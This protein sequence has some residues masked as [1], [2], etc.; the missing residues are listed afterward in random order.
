[1]RTLF[2][3][4]VISVA[5]L[6]GC[7]EPVG[8]PA[9]EAAVAA[10]RKFPWPDGDLQK[11]ESLFGSTIE[12]S[13]GLRWQPITPGTGDAHPLHGNTVTVHYRGT[14]LDGK[15]FDESYKRN[16]P[17]R[18]PVGMGRV[19]KGWDEAV[20]MMTRGE[21]RRLVVPYWLAYGP[22]GAGGAIPPKATLI[23][24]VELVGWDSPPGN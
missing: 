1:M 16:E 6:A 10:V 17:I 5:L 20:P 7:G 14:F 18:F 19:I 24:E 3:A 13:T 11:V 12:T 23:F 2:A 8:S 9:P 22:S 4:S 15:V 21:K